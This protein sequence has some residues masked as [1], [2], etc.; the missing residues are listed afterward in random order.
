MKTG[1]DK[2]MPRDIPWQEIGKALS[3]Y[4]KR[5]EFLNVLLTALLA[6]A[7][8]LVFVRIPQHEATLGGLMI[9]A[10]CLASILVATQELMGFV[11][12]VRA[13][14]DTDTMWRLPSGASAKFLRVESASI[15]FDM[16][17]GTVVISYK[18][19]RDLATLAATADE[20]K[21]DGDERA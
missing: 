2:A 20:T 13:L 3:K 7:V 15:Q 5:L 1:P 8:G 6:A 4:D 12:E 10:L 9:A 21:K 14:L 16:Q 19:I 17:P 18:T 11:K